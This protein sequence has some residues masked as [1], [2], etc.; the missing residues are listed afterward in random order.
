MNLPSGVTDRRR[1]G[2]KMLK[3]IRGVAP[4]CLRSG[5]ITET[6]HDYLIS[7]SQQFATREPK[8]ASYPVLQHTWSPVP[9]PFAQGTLQRPR[10][11]RIIDLSID[12]NELSSSDDAESD[13]ELPSN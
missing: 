11:K 2:D 5:D 7:W 13:L 12:V 4:K 6:A 9:G 3:N 1:I 8:P 10:R